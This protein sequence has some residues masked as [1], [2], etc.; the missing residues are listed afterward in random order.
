MI[1]MIVMVSLIVMIRMIVMIVMVSL[2]VMIRMIV[3]IVMVSLIVMIRMIIMI[4][5]FLRGHESCQR[6][7]R[8]HA[9][10]N[11]VKGCQKALFQEK[12]IAN[13]KISGSDVIRNPDGRLP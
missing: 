7:H 4:I 8:R 6:D 10:I 1:V 2:I 3:V 13:E 9:F 11:R 5:I 12:S